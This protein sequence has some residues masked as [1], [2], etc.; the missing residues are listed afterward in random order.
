MQISPLTCRGGQTSIL[1]GLLPID[2]QAPSFRRCRV[3]LQQTKKKQKISQNYQRFFRCREA[4]S[5][6][7]AES[8]M[9]ILFGQKQPI[10]CQKGKKESE[11][12]LIQRKSATNIDFKEQG[13]SVG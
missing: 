8:L 12:A 9:V 3:V 13:S 6:L 1:K 11:C 10:W 4:S 7:R 2:K 5:N